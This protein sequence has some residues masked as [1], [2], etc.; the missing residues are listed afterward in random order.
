MPLFCVIQSAI[1]V[2][3]SDEGIG[4]G[5]AFLQNDQPVAFYSNTLTE[6][7]LDV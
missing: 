5:G 3:P 1:A 7:E 6:T 4:V 2:D